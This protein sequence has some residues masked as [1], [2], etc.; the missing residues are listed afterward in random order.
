MAV[1]QFFDHVCHAL[2]QDL[3]KCE[4]DDD[5]IFGHVSDYF[6]VVETN[7]R[8]MLHLHYLVWL[9]GNTEFVHLKTKVQTDPIFRDR[10]IAYRIRSQAFST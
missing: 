4:G 10:L 5:G 9:I 6:D 3:L 1:A 7:G 8:G 2:F